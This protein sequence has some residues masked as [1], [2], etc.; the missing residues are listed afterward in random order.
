MRSRVTRR[1]GGLVAGLAAAALLAGCGSF[2]DV[3]DVV[4]D[5]YKRAAGQDVGSAK[6]YTASGSVSSVASSIAK[7]EKPLDTLTVA[8]RRYLQ[9]DDYLVR[10]QP[11]GGGSTVLLDNYNNGY[12]RWVSDVGQQWGSQSSGDG[13][14]GDEGK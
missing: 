12:Q 11:G 5:N 10:V 2:S 4:Q 8:D 14:P 7:K 6:A 13:G 1:A 9:Y 3:S